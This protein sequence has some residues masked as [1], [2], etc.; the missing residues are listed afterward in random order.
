MIGF[1]SN[2]I[3]SLQQY[4]LNVS[5]LSRT[6]ERANNG[7]LMI[8]IICTATINYSH[9]YLQPHNLTSLQAL[10]VISMRIVRIVSVM[11]C[12]WPLWVPTNLLLGWRQYSVVSTSRPRQQSGQSSLGASS[13]CSRKII[14]KNVW[15]IVEWLHHSLPGDW[16]YKIE[17]KVW[18]QNPLRLG[19]SHRLHS[20]W[21]QRPEPLSELNEKL[22]N[23]FT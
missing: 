19:T 9:D 3:F 20:C 10:H 12:C 15:I 14:N 6:F 7:L 4:L 17:S 11:T 18:D 1:Y 21:F 16:K 5:T 22:I 23:R 8:R 13:G 2:C